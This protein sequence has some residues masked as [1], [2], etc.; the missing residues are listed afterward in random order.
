MFPKLSAFSDQPETG[1]LA[2]LQCKLTA[3]RWSPETSALSWVGGERLRKWRMTAL[4]AGLVLLA[5]LVERAGAARLARDLLRVGWWM[6]VLLAIA[7]VRNA[8]RAQ[9]V[10]LALGEERGGISFAAMYGVLMVSEAVQFLAAAGL[11][12]GQAAKGWLL[13]RRVSGARAVSAVMVDVV[14]Y[15]L[16][17]ALFCL[18]AI[19]LFFGMHPTS[20]AER[21][22]GAFGV[23]LVMLAVIAATVA[24][25]RRWVTVRRLLT[26]LAHWGVVRR[27]ETL[28]RIEEIDAQALGFRSRHP[29]AFRL[30]LGWDFATHFLSAF[31]VM[32]ILRVL[33]LGGGYL[34]GIVIEG[35]TKIVEVGGLVVPGDVGLYQGGAG[36]IF[37]SLGYTAAAGISVG[38][39]RQIR[40]I[41]WA[42]IGI[43][44]LLSPQFA[45]RPEGR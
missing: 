29:N 16:T 43:L 45:E 18:G 5:W 10:R 24:I 27:A 41:L 42:G 12:F 30:I 15:Y 22:A 3:E 8:C 44:L 25:R 6:A 19:L 4:V 17:A 33:G 7:A 9:A 13:A 37:H 26:P 36:L 20:P 38:I 23:A 14:T 34:A 31:E 35:L 28:E 2:R 1:S 39:I 21:R 40:S 32:V 11:L